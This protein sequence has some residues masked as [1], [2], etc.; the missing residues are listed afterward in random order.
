[1]QIAKA[2]DHYEIM[3]ECD[4]AKE[5]QAT[6]FKRTRLSLTAAT[7]TRRLRPVDAIIVDYITST[8]QGA[9]RNHSGSNGITLLVRD[10]ERYHRS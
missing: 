10:I 3:V 8:G 5:S 6:P 1:M 7:H 4:R 9:H 2:A